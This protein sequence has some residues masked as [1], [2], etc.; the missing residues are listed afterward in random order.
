MLMGCKPA[1]LFPLGSENL[2]GLLRLLPSRIGRVV[3]REQG[4]RALLFLFDRP[5][6]ERTLFQEPVRGLLSDTGY[7]SRPSLPLF[8]AHLQKEFSRRPCPH[9][10][11]FFLGYPPEDVSGFIKNRGTG[12]KLCGPWKVYGNPERAKARFREYQ[13]CREYLKSR[14][15]EGGGL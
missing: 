3:I 13:A 11:G 7:P 12:F 6:L 8:L 10:V 1:V 15:G 2:E 4:G 14:L 5:L 9:E